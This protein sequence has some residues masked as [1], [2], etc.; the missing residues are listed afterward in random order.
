MSQENEDSKNSYVDV[1]EDM[2][3]QNVTKQTPSSIRKLQAVVIG[4]LVAIFVLTCIL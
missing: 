3:I 1:R 4:V 2:Q